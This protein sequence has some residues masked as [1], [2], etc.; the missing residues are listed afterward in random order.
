VKYLGKG[1]FS[2]IKRQIHKARVK[3][4]LG[5]SLLFDIGL[6]MYV[7]VSLATGRNATSAT[8]KAHWNGFEETNKNSLVS[9]QA[10]M[11]EMSI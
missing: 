3:V 7:M 5:V 1:N 2:V 4:C 6:H 8:N 11:N 9:Q 10:V